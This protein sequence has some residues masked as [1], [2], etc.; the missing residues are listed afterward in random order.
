MI[1][2]INVGASCSALGS[3]V[4]L[5]VASRKVTSFLPLGN[6]IG[7]VKGRSHGTARPYCSGQ[8]KVRD[9]VRPSA[10]KN[11]RSFR[12]SVTAINRALVVVG[13]LGTEMS[14]G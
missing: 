5:S 7:S 12:R 8:G 4:M 13:L 2:G 3:S 11:R 14:S 10:N 6:S 9:V 1:D